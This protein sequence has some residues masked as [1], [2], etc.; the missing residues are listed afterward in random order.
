MTL[1][2]ALPARHTVRERAREE[3]Q[4]CCRSRD[5][6]KKQ[7]KEQEKHNTETDEEPKQKLMQAYRD[8][9]RNSVCTNT[10]I[11][12]QAYTRHVQVIKVW[13]EQA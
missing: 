1:L 2:V 7:A 13:R 8:R 9:N 3:S 10:C 11:L 6:D 12:I 5:T 4:R